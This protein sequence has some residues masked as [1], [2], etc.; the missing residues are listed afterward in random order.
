MCSIARQARRSAASS[1]HFLW[2]RSKVTFV[3][4][5]SDA[6]S[7]FHAVKLDFTL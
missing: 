1:G 6:A 2:S 5:L 4:L 3:M 7:W